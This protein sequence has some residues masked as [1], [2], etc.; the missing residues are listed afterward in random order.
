MLL[1]FVSLKCRGHKLL[2]HQQEIEMAHFV[3]A[4]HF[5]FLAPGPKIVGAGSTYMKRC[6]FP[7]TFFRQQQSD[8]VPG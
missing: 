4:L 7:H 8:P 3:G 2:V 6:F 1:C 5:A